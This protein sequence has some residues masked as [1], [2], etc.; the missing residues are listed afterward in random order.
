MKILKYQHNCIKIEKS[1]IFILNVKI[2]KSKIFIL[3][4]LY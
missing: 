2:E 4:Y 1:K 3:K